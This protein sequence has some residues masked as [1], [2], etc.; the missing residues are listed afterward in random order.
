[1]VVPEDVQVVA[2]NVI[3]HRLG[4]AGGTEDT[5]LALTEKIIRAVPVR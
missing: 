4:S 3:A 1:M 2:P 5:G